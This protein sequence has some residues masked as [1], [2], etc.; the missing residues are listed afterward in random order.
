MDSPLYCLLSAVCCLLSACCTMTADALSPEQLAKMQRRAQ[1]Q[2]D[3]E[4][5]AG[6]AAWTG[7]AGGNQFIHSILNKDT[8]CGV[9]RKAFV[10]DPDGV[11]AGPVIE[12]LITEAIGEGFI[13]AVG[14]K[15]TFF[16]AMFSQERRSFV[17]TGS[18]QT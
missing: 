9:F 13:G 1:D 17:K 15:Q 4:R 6:L 8:P 3:G 5:M 2:L 12:Q 10:Q 18:G 14:R 7:R 16:G 11:Q